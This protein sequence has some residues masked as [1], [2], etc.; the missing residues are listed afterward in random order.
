MSNNNTWLSNRKKEIPDGVWAKCLECGEIIYNGELDRNLRI[1]RKCNYYFPFDPAG[2]ISLIAD[3]ATFHKYDDVKYSG[4]LDIDRFIISGEAL[5]SDQNM[6]IMVVN[7]N[8]TDMAT[9]FFV[10]EKIVNTISKSI[11][12]KLPLL[13]FVT[14]YA[15]L[16]LQDGIFFPGQSISI[17]AALS[18]LEI[19]RTP[20]ISV[21]SQ[22]GS[23]SS[24]PGFVYVADIVIA[25][26]NTLGESHTG[27]RIGRRES[28]RA[29]KIMFDNGIVDMVVSRRDMKERLA[30]ILSFFA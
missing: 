26:S 13:S 25:E 7:L 4:N 14:S 19:S 20:Y 24:F 21:I 8:F 22:S 10:C 2:R 9:G 12:R 30:D 29:A 3:E 17:S 15:E 27:S 28:D 5:L 6:I 1:C 18:K 23:N 11:D 16:P